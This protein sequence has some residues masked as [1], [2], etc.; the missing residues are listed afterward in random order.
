MS[1]VIN[2]DKPVDWT[3]H[4]VVAKIRS[5]L[6]R[7]GIHRV[8]HTGT[9][10]PM[11]TGVLPVC[12]G[13]ATKVSSYFMNGDK[14]YDVTCRLGQET[15]TGDKTGKVIHACDPP[16]F[17]QQ[18]LDDVLSSFVGTIMQTPPLYS[19]IKVGGVPLYKLAR[20]GIDLA[21]EP[22]PVTIKS[23]RLKRIAGN[24]LF[25]NVACTKGTYIRTLCADIGRKLG[26]FG[27]ANELR[28]LR[29]GPFTVHQSVPLHQFIQLCTVGGW[30]MR[31]VS[32]EEAVSLL[33][34]MKQTG[35]IGNNF[36]KCQGG[37]AQPC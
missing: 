26:V 5:L 24:D 35:V 33:P 1:G 17:S 11:A 28:R 37:V 27:F 29:C 30:E 18:T 32:L 15:D 19:A 25:L 2:I 13:T 31:V 34:D 12:F 6:R 4:D 10:D 21:R 16:S 20:R 9:L 8:G 14:E 3:S 23:I 22:R 7:S 36:I